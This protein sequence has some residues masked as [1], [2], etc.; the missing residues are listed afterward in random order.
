MWNFYNP[1][2]LHAGEEWLSKLDML[3]GSLSRG[4]P[5]AGI[6]TYDIFAALAESP[7]KTI[8]SHLKKIPCTIF[9]QVEPEPSNSTIMKGKAWAEANKLSAVIAIG[10]GSVIDAA[11]AICCLAHTDLHITP[12]MDRETALEKKMLPLIAIPTTAGTG[13]EVTPFCVLTNQDTGLKK[14]L[15]SPYFYPDMALLIP[16]FVTTLPQQVIADVGMDV[17]A[18]AFEAIWSIKSQPV[19]ENLA[20]AAIR[21]V[22]DHFL[23]Y[24][25]QPSNLD[26]ASHMLQAAS[27][28]GMAFSNTFTA[29]CHALSFPIGQRFHLS[30]GASCAMTLHLVAQAN[31]EAVKPSF[32]RLAVLLGLSDGADIPVF[33]EQLNEKVHATRR[34]SQLGGTAEDV[35]LIARGAFQPLLANNPVVL[36][37]M[38][39]VDL[40]SNI[41]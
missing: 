16:R 8:V 22:K 10:G 11:K 7:L 41:L 15:G 33:I 35:K 1:V 29:A 36:N 23:I 5:S 18:H 14:S 12:I 31:I 38:Q 19:S 13:S 21:M 25:E 37:E 40:L 34:F 27:I 26:A 20:F 32:D 30:H 9:D 28:A 4:T 3:I 17:L 6:I 2:Q 24:Y 39:L